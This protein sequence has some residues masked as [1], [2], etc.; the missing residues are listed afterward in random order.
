V[1]LGPGSHSQSRCKAQ[2]SET[3][4]LGAPV[5]QEECNH[6]EEGG[7]AFGG[8]GR[9]EEGA[10]QP[11]SSG[12]V[13][14]SSAASSDASSRG[15]EAIECL[16]GHPAV[17]AVQPGQESRAQPGHTCCRWQIHAK[18]KEVL[19]LPCQL[20]ALSALKMLTLKPSPFSSTPVSGAH[21]QGV[22]CNL[23]GCV[24]S[25]YQLW[26]SSASKLP[27]LCLWLRPVLLR[28]AWSTPGLLGSCSTGD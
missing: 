15:S 27:L 26:S 20:A 25:R 21:C 14:H 4:W 2:Q 23:G 1:S 24:L 8:L 22:G 11:S 9:L 6:S 19:T 13:G 3:L 7:K 16:C 10:L 5:L 17:A 12:C 28:P 18:E